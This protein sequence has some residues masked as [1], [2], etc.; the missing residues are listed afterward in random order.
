MLQLQENCLEERVHSNIQDMKKLEVLYLQDNKLYGTLPAE[1]CEL[2]RLRLL[3]LSN[4][5]LRGCLPENIGRLSNLESLLIAGNN[6]VG[7]VPL[8]FGELQKLRDLTLFKSYPS[9]LCTPKRAFDRFAFNR[10]YLEGPKHGINSIHWDY[11]DVYGRERTAADDE[12][13]TIFSG[14][15]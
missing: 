10:I 9:E 5:N 15:Y 11:K 1:L 14:K 8:S 2:K 7:P 6:I 4:N 13:V 12:S 3:N